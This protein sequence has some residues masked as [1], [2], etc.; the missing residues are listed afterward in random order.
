MI[1]I[2]LRIINTYQQLTSKHLNNID[3]N[4]VTHIRTYL[5]TSDERQL[6][7][8]EKTNKTNTN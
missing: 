8:Q 7:Q 6:Q 5:T 3:H 2:V 1:I 4:N